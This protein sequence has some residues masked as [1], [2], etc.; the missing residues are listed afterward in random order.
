[1]AIIQ[2]MFCQHTEN[3]ASLLWNKGGGGITSGRYR[4]AK[5]SKRRKTIEGLADLTHSSGNKKNENKFLE[6]PLNPFQTSLSPL[7]NLAC[8]TQ[9]TNSSLPVRKD[10][11][12]L[13]SNYLSQGAQEASNNKWLLIKY[14][15][16]HCQNLTVDGKE[17]PHTFLNPAMQR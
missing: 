4:K 16:I 1:M 17:Q 2:E 6:T 10:W 12:M 5:E 11:L 15:Q 8:L 9:Q 14:V 13:S 3:E 7:D